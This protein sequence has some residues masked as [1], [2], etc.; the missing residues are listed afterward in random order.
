LLG[1]VLIDAKFVLVQ[2]SEISA[3]DLI[4]LVDASVRFL[5]IPVS[6]EGNKELESSVNVIIL[7]SNLLLIINNWHNNNK[8]GGV[9]A[10]ILLVHDHEIKLLAH[11]P[12]Q[13]QQN[14]LD[15]CIKCNDLLVL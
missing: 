1:G 14:V 15:I 4:A 5:R 13:V 8:A 7:C 10:E 3:A 2:L 6:E 12:E 9:F 11:W